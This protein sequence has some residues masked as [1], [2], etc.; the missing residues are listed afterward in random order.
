LCCTAIVALP[1]IRLFF[2]ASI[3]NKYKYF[4]GPYIYVLYFSLI[5]ICIYFVSFRKLNLTLTKA[6]DNVW[7]IAFVMFSLF[8][9]IWYLYPIVDQMKL[10]LK[11]ADQDDC[12]IIGASHLAN[13]SHPYIE[14]SYFGNPCSTGMGML[15]LYLP[16]VMLN[17]YPVGSLIAILAALSAVKL[18]TRDN[19]SA[20]TFLAIISTSLITLEQLVAGSDLILLG[21]GLVVMLIFTII[22]VENKSY[23]WL[24]PCAILTGLLSSTRINFIV[25]FP[26]I[27]LLVF[28]HW[29]RGML[30]FFIT[31][32]FVAVI[33]SA[34][35]Y[36][37]NPAEFT[38][39]HLLA[40]S[41]KLL[42]TPFTEIVACLSML[43]AIQSA[44][45]VRRN[46]N[47]LPFSF[48]LTIAPGLIALSVGDLLLSRAGN[49]AT[50]EG[51]NYMIPLIPLAAALLSVP[52]F[53]WAE[54]C[55][56]KLI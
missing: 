44:L 14:R 6:V 26:L 52:K 16:F 22:A 46:L 38:P 15:I 33:P 17:L 20:S 48:F 29:P 37:I 21:C 39:F 11:G 45:I 2:V 1:S 50:W 49:I 23:Y 28:A 55:R 36:H 53:S 4:Q 56:H 54:A 32:L 34:F 51:A 41:G 27:S 35:V 8:I 9:F 3:F 12:V 18:I 43:L 25:I 24:I 42:P 13:F 31:S 19:Y 10:Q 40:K 7:L 30:L 47:L 5:S